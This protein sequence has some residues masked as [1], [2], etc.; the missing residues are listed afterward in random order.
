MKMNRK[1]VY[2]D[3]DIQ[4]E[5]AKIIFNPVEFAEFLGSKGKDVTLI[6]EQGMTSFRTAPMKVS[7]F[8]KYMKEYVESKGVK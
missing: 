4:F 2:E 6:E 8:Q 1:F 7:E 3:G 5:E